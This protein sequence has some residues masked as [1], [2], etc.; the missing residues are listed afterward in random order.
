MPTAARLI[1]AI[2]LAIASAFVVKI[3]TEIHPDLARDVNALAATAAGVGFLVGWRGLGRKVGVEDTKASRLG[4][5]AGVSVFL[6]TLFF[7]AFWFMIQGIIDWNYR[8][9][10][11]AV[12][13]IPRMMINYAKFAMNWQTITAIVILS[14]IGGVITHNAWKKWD[15]QA[16]S[17]I[18]E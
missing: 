14:M 3:V 10:M 12:L 16:T 13:Q 17:T 2:Y 8:Q 15:K 18:I 9:P 6:W 4:L 11:T 7:Y 1:S 5:R